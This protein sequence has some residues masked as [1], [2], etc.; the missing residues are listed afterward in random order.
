MMKLF[1]EARKKIIGLS[2]VV[3]LMLLMMN[4]N[5]RLNEYFRLT[6]ERNEVSTQVNDL[7]ITRFALETQ[8]AYATSDAAVDEWARGE[9]HLAQPGDKVIV[10]V[11]PAN[12]T[13]V[14]EPQITPT[15]PVI[16]NYEVWWALFFGE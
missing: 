16:E 3:L 10:P 2:A 9:A 4:I 13:S 15:P 12:L 8:V 14:Q 6:N 1:W 5:S 11:T 7:Q